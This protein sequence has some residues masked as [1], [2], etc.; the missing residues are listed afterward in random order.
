MSLAAGPADDPDT[1]V[2]EPQLCATVAP[3]GNL[4]AVLLDALDND[5]RHGLGGLYYGVVLPIGGEDANRDLDQYAAKALH[6]APR[7]SRSRAAR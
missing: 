2:P 3:D 7:I 1:A 4:L 5:T 6:V